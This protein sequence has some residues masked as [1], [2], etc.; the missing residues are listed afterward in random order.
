MKFVSSR[1]FRIKPGEIWEMLE[2]GEDVVITSH[3]K[4][5]G[6]LIGANEDNMQLLLNEL[7]R[8]KAKIA[9]TNLRLQAQASGADKLS[10]TDIDRL[11]ED[12][13]KGY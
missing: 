2:A 13:R 4:P 12:S 1:D 7:T 5:L 6:V 9:V 3:G 11:I 8:L 10:E